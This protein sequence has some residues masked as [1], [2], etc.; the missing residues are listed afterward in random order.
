M[1]DINFLYGPP[2]P[3]KLLAKKLVDAASADYRL[4][5]MR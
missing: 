1:T 4:W 3:A 2:S 5:T